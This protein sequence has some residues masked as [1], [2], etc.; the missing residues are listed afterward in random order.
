MSAPDIPQTYSVTT[1]MQGSLD[2]DLDEIRIREIPLIRSTVD[3]GLDDI[4]IKQLPK[5]VTESEVDLGLDN[6]RIREL[7]K[8]DLN[9]EVGM[10]PTRVH[11]PVNLHFGLSVLGMELFAFNVCGETMTIVEDYVPHATEKCG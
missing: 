9:L 2:L 5:I 1:T 6:I 3:L 8:I 4:R 7:P 10:R 11:L